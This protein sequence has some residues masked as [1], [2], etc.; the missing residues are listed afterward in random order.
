MK[1]EAKKTD[2][3]LDPVKKVDLLAEE[4]KVDKKKDKVVVKKEVTEVKAK[5]RY[6]RVSPKKVM[7]V[8]GV[9][10]GMKVDKALDQLLFIN[11]GATKPV[12]KLLN[13]AIANAKHN[14]ELDE[15]DLYIKHIVANQ[16]PTLHRWKPAAFGRAH[17]IRKR[18]T[19]LELILG[20][21]KDEK[22]EEVKKDVK[23]E[24]KKDVKKKKKVV[25]KETK[26]K[27]II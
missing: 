18:T 1:K 17:P 26:K 15:N 23:T 19:H 3:K 5:A 11:K 21:K 12:T 4:K 7:L 10:R 9:I 13:S 22:V 6:L 16:G 25:K 27:D 2:K 14:F 24:V 8:I 20:I